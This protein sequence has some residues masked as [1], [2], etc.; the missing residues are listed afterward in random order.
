MEI[1]VKGKK[2]EG[3]TTLVAVLR[4]VLPRAYK[5]T[6]IEDGRTDHENENIECDPLLLKQKK[7]L[8]IKTEDT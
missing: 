4:R 7:E 3:K 2:G 6:E 1:V 5:I 8:S